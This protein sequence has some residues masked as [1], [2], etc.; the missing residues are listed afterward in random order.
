MKDDVKPKAII[1]KQNEESRGLEKMILKKNLIR[2][3]N[4]L[5]RIVKTNEDVF[6]TFITITFEE[7]VK[8]LEH[9]NKMFN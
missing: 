4:Q 8:D 5:K 3:Q 1:K 7:N 9:A 2:A 6:K